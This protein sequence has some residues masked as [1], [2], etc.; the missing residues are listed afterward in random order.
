MTDNDNR[1]QPGVDRAR[2]PKKPDA[3][4]PRDPLTEE[5][6]EAL[7]DQDIPVETGVPPERK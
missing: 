2:A 5:V 1:K 4:K 3:R 6:E 7:L